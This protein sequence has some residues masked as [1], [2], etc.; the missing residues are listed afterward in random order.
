MVA[1]AWWQTSL[2]GLGSILAF[3]YELV[4]SY[5][6]AIILLTLLVRVAL[7]PLTVKQVR[8]MRSSQAAMRRVQPKIEAIRKKYRGNR[9]R[10]NE[11]MMK[12]YREEGV[13]P[14]AGCLPLV[15]VILQ[16]PVFIA[17]F[18]VLRGDP[19]KVEALYPTQEGVNPAIA[20]LPE[21]SSLGQ[22]IQDQRAGFVSMN[23]T[24]AAS[25][26]GRGQVDL[27]PGPEVARVDCGSGVLAASPFYVL[28][29]LMILTTWYQ[30]RQ[31][32]TTATSGVQAQQMQMMG[33]IMPLFLGVFS[34]SIPAGVVLYWVTTNAWQIGQ[35]QVM[36]PPKPQE[37]VETRAT[38]P[39]P[40]GGRSKG[41]RNAGSRKKRRK[42]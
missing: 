11:E 27:V 41:S 8:S 5:G 40:S 38:P 7:L 39:K 13:N 25:Q 15:F 34:Y 35:Q 18:S 29:G 2:E 24:C 31:M 3:F 21:G 12:V 23:L 28:I 26:G 4:P 33:R 32:Q 42:R 22:A 16:A 20:H 14:A 17:L 9:Q 37:E 1:L 10:I 36:L 19:N 6:V 30:Q